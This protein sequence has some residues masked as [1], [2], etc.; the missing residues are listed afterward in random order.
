MQGEKVSLNA[1][2]VDNS[3]VTFIGWKDESGNLV[4]LT[5]AT[6]LKNTSLYA[7][8]ENDY[9][10]I[11]FFGDNITYG[12]GDN[13]IKTENCYVN[14]V[15]ETLNLETVINNGVSSTT[16]CLESKTGSVFN[17][18]EN[19]DRLEKNGQVAEVVI[20]MAGVN[21]F[22]KASK[23]GTTSYYNLG[24]FNSTTKTTIYGSARLWCEKINEYKAMDKY[25]NTR[26]VICTPTI[27][28]WNNSV[29]VARNFAESG[30]KIR[31]CISENIISVKIIR[32]KSKS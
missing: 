24:T 14:K 10:S 23:N 25:K 2:T 9:N 28:S 31:F 29:T 13:F 22:D 11:A 16:F 15:A 7:H 3:N 32:H 21:D 20:I 18:F 27:T 12:I 19:T 6:F 1:P 4:D 8:F 26:F 17:Y 5:N 30:L